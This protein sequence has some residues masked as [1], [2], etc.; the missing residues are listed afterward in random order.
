MSVN[1]SAK[2]TPLEFRRS[3]PKAQVGDLLGGT[4]PAELLKCAD[5]LR[6]FVH[7]A[8]KASAGDERIEFE[9]D[10]GY[11]GY[12]SI[13]TVYIREET[14]TEMAERKKHLDARAQEHYKKNRK[15]IDEKKK[16]L[17]AEI[18]RIDAI[19]ADVDREIDI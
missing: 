15:K 12:D 17:L 3:G 19:K 5:K 11:D 16:K 6:E 9:L 18:A 10:G 14:D 7:K 1:P 2:L 8:Q 4:T 13:H